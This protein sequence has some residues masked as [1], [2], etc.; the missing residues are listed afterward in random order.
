LLLTSG[1]IIFLKVPSASKHE[2]D[3]TFLLHAPSCALKANL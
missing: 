3:I 1:Q 2:L